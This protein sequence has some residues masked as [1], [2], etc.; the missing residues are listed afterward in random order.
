MRKPNS[1]KVGRKVVKKT[2]VALGRMLALRGGDGEVDSSRKPLNALAAGGGSNMQLVCVDADCATGLEYDLDYM[3]YLTIFKESHQYLLE[4][5]ASPLRIMYTADKEVDDEK[6]RGRG[7]GRGRE[8]SKPPLVSNVS[9]KL[10]TGGARR[11]DHNKSTVFRKE[12]VLR[13]RKIGMT[14]TEASLRGRKKIALSKNTI[15][16]EPKCKHDTKQEKD[17]S[18]HKNAM[19]VERTRDVKDT[20]QEKEVSIRGRKPKNWN[21]LDNEE[22]RRRRKAIFRASKRLKAEKIIT[23]VNSKDA[24]QGKKSCV[25]KSDFKACKKENEESNSEKRKS[26]SHEIFRAS[27]RL[28][29]DQN[30]VNDKLKKEEVVNKDKAKPKATSHVK[31]SLLHSFR[32][33]KKVENEESSRRTLMDKSYEYFIAFLRNSVTVIEVKP[34]KASVPLSDPDIIAVSNCPFSDGGPSPFEANKDGKVIDLEDRIEPEDMFNSTFSK[35]LLE[36]LRQPYDKNEF[37]QRLFEASQKKQLTRSRQ[38]RDGREIE[39]NV[40]HQL[41]PSYFDRYP[42]F[43][44]VFRRSRSAKDDHRALNLLRGFFFYFE[45]QFFFL[46]MV[47]MKLL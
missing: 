10:K 1:S 21:K 24:P 6:R 26:K 20:H 2:L 43:K 17:A 9:K 36:I 22:S 41:G 7:R 15:K 39:Y 4:G 13:G 45:V 3:K 33:H 14:K 38:L 12:V 32:P 47:V 28:K 46:C 23:V 19:K 25:N 37:K 34:E 29:T 40:D 18:L 16:L 31:D 11:E 5:E 8:R 42:D 44:R 30:L 27:K 35:K